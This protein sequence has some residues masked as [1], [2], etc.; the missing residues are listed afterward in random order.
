MVFDAGRTH[1]TRIL[2]FRVSDL[3][4]DKRPME[5]TIWIY[6]KQSWAFDHQ[7]VILKINS[8]TFFVN[9]LIFDVEIDQ[10]SITN[11]VC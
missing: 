3:F 8:S 6:I 4:N 7:L 1:K 11:E 2:S 5:L 10:F 9:S